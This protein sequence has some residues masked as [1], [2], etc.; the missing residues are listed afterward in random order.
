MSLPTLDK[1]H[2]AALS[3]IPLLLVMLACF[4]VGAIAT[5]LAIEYDA[6]RLWRF[7]LNRKPRDAK[8]E[9]PEEAEHE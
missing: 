1:V 2:D 6:A 3:G 8:A 4:L 9:I 5:R 7:I